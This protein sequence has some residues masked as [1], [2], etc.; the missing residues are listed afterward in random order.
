MVEHCDPADTI[1]Y[2][3]IDWSEEHRYLRMAERKKPWV[4]L[5]PLCDPPYLTKTDLHAWGEREGLRKQRL[6]ELGAAHANC[7]GG[8]VKMGQG[9]FARLLS[10]DRPRFL[11]WEQHEQRLRDQLGNVAILRD[12]RGG[13]S[14]PPPLFELRERLEGGGQVDL[15]DVG[16]CGCFLD[17]EA[18]DAA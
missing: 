13:T 14:R 15:F 11:E 5:A 4:Y 10:A 9:G 6:Y 12:R 7:G 8:C 1:G 2:V 3:G 17:G 16:G 18:D